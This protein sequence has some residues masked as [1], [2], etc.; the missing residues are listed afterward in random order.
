MAYS[1]TGQWYWFGGY[2]IFVQQIDMS[3]AQHSLYEKKYNYG[4]DIDLIYL[5]VSALSLGLITVAGILNS[6]IR[7]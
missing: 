3:P 6:K 4:A 1:R 7:S 5:L 2:H